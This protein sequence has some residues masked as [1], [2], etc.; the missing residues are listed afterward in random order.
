MAGLLLGKKECIEVRSE[1]VRRR[2]FVGE[3][4]EVTPCR[5]AK[6]EQGAGT[7]SGVWPVCGV[8]SVCGVWRLGLSGAE[9]RVREGVSS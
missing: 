9:W 2:G 5:A 3:E 7:N 4:G 6:D 1:G 8:W